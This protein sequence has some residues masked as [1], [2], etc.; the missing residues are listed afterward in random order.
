MSVSVEAKIIVGSLFNGTALLIAQSPN[1]RIRCCRT[2]RSKTNSLLSKPMRGYLSRI[3][4][5]VLLLVIVRVTQ[6]FFLLQRCGKD[7]RQK[8]SDSLLGEF[9]V[10][11][12]VST[13]AEHEW[14]STVFTILD[15]SPLMAASN[16]L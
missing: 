11:D 3:C 12:S 10:K 5:S 16:R 8:N 4:S 14:S 1:T 2:D 15:P 9:L 6:L 13:E 7:S